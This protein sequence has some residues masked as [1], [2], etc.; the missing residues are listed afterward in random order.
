MYFIPTRRKAIVGAASV[1]A[2][3]GMGS[4]SIALAPWW[5]AFS[6]AFSAQLATFGIVE[7][8]KNWGFDLGTRTRTSVQ[9]AHQQEV[10]PLRNRGFDIRPLYAG[11]Y[12]RGDF[13]VSEAVQGED[14]FAL[15]TT[16][17]SSDICTLRFRPADAIHIGLVSRAFHKMGLHSSEIEAATLPLYRQEGTRFFFGDRKRS[18]TYVTPSRGTISWSTDFA[19]DTPNFT[20][21]IRSNVVRV[22]LRFLRKNGRWDLTMSFV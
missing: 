22:D 13:E 3:M 11:G 9:T 14:Y 5:T 7:A 1:I 8:L 6:A 15:S 17:R 16:N 12:S 4:R 19:I 2:T 21:L 18:P 10:A 20:T